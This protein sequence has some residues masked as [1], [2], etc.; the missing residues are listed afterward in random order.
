MTTPERVSRN[1]GTRGDFR[2][3]LIVGYIRRKST[4]ARSGREAWRS[5]T[6]VNG[7]LADS[8]LLLLRGGGAFYT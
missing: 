2:A 5:C 7:W 8:R 3:A 6:F 4:S 1:V